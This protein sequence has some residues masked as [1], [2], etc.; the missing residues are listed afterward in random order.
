MSGHSKWSNI[1]NRK[2]AQDQKKGKVFSE[3]AKLIR[4]AVK[5]HGSGDP[6]SNPTL[7]LY[8]DKA[9]SV[10]M[11]KVNIDRAINKGLGKGSEGAHF[12]EIRYEGFGPGGVGIIAIVITDNPNRTASQ[13]KFI[14]SRHA[15]TLGGPNSVSYMFSRTDGGEY[16]STIPAPALSDQQKQ[17]LDSLVD[18]LLEDD[19]VEEV[20]TQVIG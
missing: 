7:R 11:P 6:T 16:V 9:R 14:F 5:E 8:L 10:N 4:V 17:E 1:K 15:G 13:I 20:F 18:A 2:E 3:L 19:D 12:Q